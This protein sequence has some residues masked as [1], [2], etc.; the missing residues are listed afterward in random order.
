VAIELPAAL[1]PPGSVSP[2]A[3]P[4]GGATRS[5][6]LGAVDKVGDLWIVGVLVLMLAVFGLLS[7]DHDMFTRASWLNTSQYAV[8][9]LLLAIGETFVILTGGVDLSDGAV[10]GFTGMVSGWVMQE[11]LNSHDG[12]VITTIAGFA[13]ALVLGAFI[14]FINGYI[15]TRLKLP[16]F[17]VTL[18]TLTAFGAAPN[19]VN[20]GNEVTTLPPQISSLGAELIANWLYLIFIIAAVA[21]VVMGLVLHRTRFGL[22]T[23]A[24]GSNNLGARRAGINVDRHLVMVYTLSGLLAGLAGVMVMAKFSTASPTSGQNDELNAIA[25]V[26]IGG[27]SLFG[28][29]GHMLGTVVGT[30]IIAVLTT[31]LVLVGV[32]G[33]WQQVAEGAIIVAAVAIDQVRL[34]LAE[35]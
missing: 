20:G 16:P 30:F 12:N 33:S 32:S 31:G 34:R 2:K 28:G 26:I 29:R 24:I 6:W 8:E 27:A 10:L 35:K 13:V 5:S 14:G 11:M 17:I 7:P 1:R 9:F 25:A 22:R 15:I 3:G 21:C 23:Y 4:E 18:G 19:L